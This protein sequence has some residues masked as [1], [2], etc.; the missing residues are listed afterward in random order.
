MVLPGDP[1][2]WGGGG[3]LAR[4]RRDHIDFFCISFI[5]YYILYIIYE[6]FYITYLCMFFV[7]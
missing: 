1:S 4:G 3:D 2:H 7:I 5:V 6:L